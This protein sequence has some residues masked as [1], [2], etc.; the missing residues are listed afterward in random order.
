M[1][2]NAGEQKYSY[3]FYRYDLVEELCNSDRVLF[4]QLFN[5]LWELSQRK[6]PA[7]GS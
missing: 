1:V 5:R 3:S 7:P 4:K 6:V 2:W